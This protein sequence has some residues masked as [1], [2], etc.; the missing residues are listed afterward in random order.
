MK[1]RGNG[2]ADTANWQPYGTTGAGPLQN[3]TP[4]PWDD[5]SFTAG[6][7]GRATGSAIFQNAAR[8]QLATSI[9]FFF[10]VRFSCLALTVVAQDSPPSSSETKRALLR[11]PAGFLPQYA[12]SIFSV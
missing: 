3:I 10:N 4:P 8:G 12:M 11:G 7:E 1:S 2:S 5:V 9:F 6:K